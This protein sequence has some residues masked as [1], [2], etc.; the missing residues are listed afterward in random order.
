MK[1]KYNSEDSQYIYMPGYNSFQPEL[2]LYTTKAQ[3]NMNHAD[4]KSP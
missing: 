4:M 3:I 2:Y 1:C